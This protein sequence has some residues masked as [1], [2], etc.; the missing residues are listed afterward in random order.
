MEDS[1]PCHAVAKLYSPCQRP[2]EHAWGSS[3][4]L[5][6]LGNAHGQLRESPSNVHQVMSSHSGQHQHGD[7]Q[8]FLGLLS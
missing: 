4:A 5:P 6:Q 1:F 3:F 8:S 7:T 2:K